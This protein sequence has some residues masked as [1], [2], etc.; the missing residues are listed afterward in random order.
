MEA[1]NS[2]EFESV[3]DVCNSSHTH[4]MTFSLSS[5]NE[6]E[7]VVLPYSQYKKYLQTIAKYDKE[8]QSDVII[9]FGDHSAS[10]EDD[11]VSLYEIAD[12]L[13]IEKELIKEVIIFFGNDDIFRDTGEGILESCPFT[14]YG[15]KVYLEYKKLAIHKL[16]TKDI[17]LQNHIVETIY[18]HL[19]DNHSAYISDIDINSILCGLTDHENIYALETIKLN[20]KL[21]Y[22]TKDLQFISL[23]QKG[24]NQYS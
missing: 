1:Y 4:N 8:L 16:L 6:Q 10:S 14:P 12:Y 5:T 24:R 19:K 17:E 15:W 13:D 7:C 18:H 11:T 23:T 3:N 20:P 9:A 21:F 2:E 22:T